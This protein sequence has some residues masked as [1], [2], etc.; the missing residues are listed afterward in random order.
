MQLS[1]S[2][3]YF[4]C[5][6]Y[7]WEL[8]K[9]YCW[10]LHHTGYPYTSIKSNYIT[11]HDYILNNTDDALQIDHIDIN[12]LNNCRCNLRL[13]TRSQNMMNRNI[14]NNNTSGCTGVHYDSKREK[15]IARIGID[16]KRINLG[17]FDNIEDAIVIRKDAEI[18]YFGEFRRIS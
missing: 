8:T 9:E 5:N 10:A 2:D 14:F 13:A 18:K 7:D 11:F 17:A 15:W 3:E 1:N 4:I 16:N 6:L 12:P